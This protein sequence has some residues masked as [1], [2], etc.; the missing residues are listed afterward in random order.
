MRICVERMLVL[1]DSSSGISCWIG[2]HAKNSVDFYVVVEDN[3]KYKIKNKFVY[4]NEK[5]KISLCGTVLKYNREIIE[6]SKIDPY[7][8]Y[9]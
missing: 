7:H 2:Q 3:L 6:R 4:K 5:Q 1:V 9:T 8:T